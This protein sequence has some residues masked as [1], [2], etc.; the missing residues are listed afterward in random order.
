MEEYKNTVRVHGEPGDEKIK[1]ATEQFMQKV[2]RK[3][4]RGNEKI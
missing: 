1:A 4:R 2:S 3:K